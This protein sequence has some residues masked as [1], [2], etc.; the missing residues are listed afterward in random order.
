MKQ[1][2]GR[3]SRLGS[4]KLSNDSTMV[5]EHRTTGGRNEEEEPPKVCTWGEFLVRHYHHFAHRW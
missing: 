2:L 1:R 3:W 4:D 5:T